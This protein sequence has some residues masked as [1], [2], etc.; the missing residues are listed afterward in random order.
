MIFVELFAYV[1]KCK[2]TDNTKPNV[3]FFKQHSLTNSNAFVHPVLDK[4]KQ[5]I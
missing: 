1:S 2:A 5:K 4:V 3:A